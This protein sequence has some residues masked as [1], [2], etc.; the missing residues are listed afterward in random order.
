MAAEHLLDLGH[1]NIGLIMKL[2]DK[3]GPSRM[4]GFLVGLT[5][6]NVPFRANWTRF[7]TTETQEQT[8]KHYANLL[9]SADYVERPSA[10]FCYNDQI[11]VNFIKEMYSR[12][13]SVPGDISVMGYDDSNLAKI[14]HGGLTTIVHPKARMG[15]QAADMLLSQIRRQPVEPYMF[16]PE[17][18]VRGS[19]GEHLS[20]VKEV[21]L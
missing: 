13:L 12:G 4:E 20:R 16:A 18:M 8:P 11:A 3:Q 21:S 10:V 14:V 7:F 19:T 9:M 2:D 5:Q 17:L 6:G 1:K 15:Y